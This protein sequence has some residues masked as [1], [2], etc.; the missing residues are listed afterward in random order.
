M[1]SN[2]E[3]G[4]FEKAIL[5]RCRHLVTLSSGLEIKG[6][7]SSVLKDDSGK[8]IYLRFEGETELGFLG[9]TLPGQ[10][11]AKACSKN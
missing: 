9:K 10:S 3:A 5:L 11:A 4:N 1:K 8:I 7:P 2:P 6:V